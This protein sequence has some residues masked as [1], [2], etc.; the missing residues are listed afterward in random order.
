MGKITKEKLINFLEDISNIFGNY[1]DASDSIL[2]LLR[3]L[4]LKHISDEFE[5]H[6]ENLFSNNFLLPEEAKWTEIENCSKNIHLKIN[7]SFKLI[8]KF[9]PGLKD[10]FLSN[11]IEKNHILN[12]QRL[13]DIV[14]KFSANKFNSLNLESNDLLGLATE[15]L[16]KIFADSSLKNGEENYT[17]PELLK[18]L[19]QLVKPKSGMTIYDP[20]CGTGGILIES[21]NYL[22]N[23]GEEFRN[24]FLY[25]QE[26]NKTSWSI[27]NINILLNGLKT[28][29][30]SD[31]NIKFGD[32]LSNPKHISNGKI[33]KFD[34]VIAN[35]PFSLKNWGIEKA[36]EDKFERY[37]FGLPPKRDGT[38]AFIQH[39]I[40][41]LNDSG[42]MAVIVSHGLLFRKGIESDI[43]KKILECDFL[44]AVIGLPK[45]LFYGTNI[46]ASILIFN[47]NKIEEHRNKVLFVDASNN[48]EKFKEKN[49]LGDEAISNIV[50]I[51]DSFSDTEG[52]SKVMTIEDLKLN[53]FNTYVKRY[54]D[55]S[56]SEVYNLS[57]KYKNYKTK[58]FS[59]ITKEVNTDQ[60][61]F[62]DHRN[63]I[64]L[65]L[66]PDG[67]CFTELT[68][69]KNSHK[70]YFQIVLED[71]ILNKYLCLFLK[72]NIGRL[73]LDEAIKYN[74]CKKYEW[75]GCLSELKILIPDLE[76]QEKQI[77][78]QNNLDY[79]KNEITDLEYNFAFTSENTNKNLEAVKRMRES[80][81]D[82]SDAEKISRLSGKKES[83]TLEFKESFSL[84]KKAWDYQNDTNKDKKTDKNLAKVVI[85]KEDKLEESCIKTINGFLNTEG[86]TLLIGVK[87]PKKGKPN[88]I[89]GINPELKLFHNNEED[90]FK[91]YFVSKLESSIDNYIKFENDIKFKVVKVVDKYVFRIDC[92]P[93]QEY[94]YVYK[95]DF[96][97]RKN[98]STHKLSTKEYAEYVKRN[99][100]G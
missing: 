79:L 29:K 69:L 73:I 20:T 95:G 65:N 94:V 32:T 67:G 31:Q 28:F 64:Y 91:R 48:Y 7:N 13:K 53:N 49:I 3:I 68:E 58:L 46:P 19:V 17:P 84:N 41:S 4:F 52:Y 30:D 82:I 99:P 9:N 74:D 80:I 93:P 10:V 66:S 6:K 54:A 62:K 90:D 18:L 61:K 70:N 39:M 42:I 50:Q 34:R 14:D 51:F 26:M 35:P 77:E 43:R 36:Q 72:S 87:E 2:Y 1:L 24:I 40:S 78:F 27:C 15:I 21:K 23:K 75:D 100:R 38:M 56:A 57:K 59:L 11:N 33:M 81:Q 16:I 86:G 89:V 63:S 47:K 45:S 60:T 44:E 85:K 76:N 83:K 37:N 92:K 22:K 88:Q 8:E 25:G 12:D 71:S 96:F 98:P 55:T 5:V 97:I